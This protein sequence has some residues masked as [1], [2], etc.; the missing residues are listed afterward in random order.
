MDLSLTGEQRA[1]FRRD[2]LAAIHAVG[3][4]IAHTS[5]D[6]DE[7]RAGDRRTMML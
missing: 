1:R 5:T 7:D 3:S 4:M 2:W 6:R